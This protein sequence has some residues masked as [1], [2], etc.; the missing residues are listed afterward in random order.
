MEGN[1]TC[2]PD[3][4]RANWPQETITLYDLLQNIHDMLTGWSAT[5]FEALAIG[6]P[7]VTYYKNLPFNP[8]N[9]P[10]AGKKSIIKNMRKYLRL[11]KIIKMKKK[12]FGG[13]PL[14]IL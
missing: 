7:V 14:K 12:Q 3:N 4:I 11:E 1:G 8:D 10:F 9:I 6:I 5:G 2:F 13:L